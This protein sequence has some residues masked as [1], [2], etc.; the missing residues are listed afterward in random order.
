MQKLKLP[1]HYQSI[2]IENAVKYFKNYDRGQ[3]HMACGTGKTLTSLWIAQSLNVNKI[4]V[5]L[6]SL[7]LQEQSLNIWMMEAKF[8]YFELLAVGSDNSFSKKYNVNA[9]TNVLEIQQF[10][11]KEGP[12][13]IF[14]TYQSYDKLLEACEG[15]LTFD[16][17]IIDE[18]HNVAGHNEKK[19]SKLLFDPEKAIVKKMLFMTGTPKFFESGSFVSMN[20]ESLFGKVIYNLSTDEAI[21]QD[22]LSDYKILVMYIS[23][24]E[25][26]NQESIIQS[27]ILNDSSIPLKYIALKA[28]VE[29]AVA[30][31][32]LKKLLSF[33]NS[34]ERANKFSRILNSDLIKTYSINC[35]QNIQK[36]IELV[37]NYKKDEVSCIC[38]PRIM[39]EG[40][41]LPQIDS[42]LFSDIK[43][44]KQDISQAI[45]RALRKFPQKNISYILLP[46]FINED[47]IINKK[48]YSIYSEMLASV[49][50]NDGRVYNQFAY[51]IDS[52]GV[53]E[54][55]NPIAF[56]DTEVNQ[57]HKSLSV[58]VW[59][60]IGKSQFISYEKFRDLIKEN[61]ITSVNQ[62]FSYFDQCNGILESK[63]LIPRR[64][65]RFY[66][67]WESWFEVFGYQTEPVISYSEFK[68][69]MKEKYKFHGINSSK[70]YFAWAY[71]K[72][73][74]GVPFP[75][76]FPRYPADFYKEWVDWYEL[77]D[78]KRKIII[79]Y[80]RFKIEIKK[81]AFLFQANYE[82]EYIKWSRG[83]LETAIIFPETFPATPSKHYKDWEGWGIIFN[84]KKKKFLNYIDFK[85]KIIYY[86]VNYQIDSARKYFRWT[87]GK[88]YNEVS[89]P[90]NFPKSPAN[91]YKKNWEGWPMLYE[92]KWLNY[93]E[94]KEKLLDYI[95]NCPLKS[96]IDYANWSKG[97]LTVE[98][99]FPKN[100][101]KYPN[102]V[103]SEWEGWKKILNKEK[104]FLNYVEF[105][106][107]L[108]FYKRNYGVNSSSKY[109]KWHLKK[110][111]FGVG[112]PAFFPK[113]PDGH[114]KEWQGWKIALGK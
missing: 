22:I 101:P 80:E 17:A 90:E 32:G 38:N 73:Y 71:N 43:K 65:N 9:T 24:K 74:F 56:S 68:K 104:I 92:K 60:K 76:N 91:H 27:I 78:K 29:K 49:A 23:E 99:P 41:D 105:V 25:L 7:Q 11:N 106:Q 53:V 47:G 28:Y 15:K 57:L 96:G 39:I 54:M 45:G 10:L 55:I 20:N 52:K 61:N 109:Q 77:F 63:Q 21:K 83:K 86:S 34:K 107:S 112:F 44:S 26:I 97:K 82:K 58:R 72:K 114:Y 64:P 1:R 35:T 67:E 69:L 102:E 103:Y 18:S 81:Y 42:I 87:T 84:K 6:P 113:Y 110:E 51:D 16:F 40:F 62:Y 111:S 100:F 75:Q 30:Q 98:V 14:S 85:E 66:K 89:F 95:D 19:F 46:I 70:K 50:L 79:N 88:E 8:F 2:A 3:L 4:V 94:Y 37:D 36:R 5:I 33:H 59:N 31:Y 12:K 108:R 48:D 13:I 93:T